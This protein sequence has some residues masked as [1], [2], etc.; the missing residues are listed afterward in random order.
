MNIPYKIRQEIIV[1][2]SRS[3]THT[4]LVER[5]MRRNVSVNLFSDHNELAH[6]LKHFN[7]DAAVITME[8]NHRSAFDTLSCIKQVRPVLPAVIVSR[9]KYPELMTKALEMNAYSF[10]TEPV[11]YEIFDGIMRNALSRRTFF[12]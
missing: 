2:E 4:A 8:E 11:N 12:S 7:P 5:L 9:Y 6:F 10:I 3:H 1:W